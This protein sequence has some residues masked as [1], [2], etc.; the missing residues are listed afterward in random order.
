MGGVGLGLEYR[1]T[2]HLFGVLVSSV[3]WNLQN[4]TAGIDTNA[5]YFSGL[6]YYYAWS[7]F[8]IPNIIPSIGFGSQSSYITDGE[9]TLNTSGFYLLGDIK[10][11]LTKNRPKD[12]FTPILGERN[13]FGMGFQY[14]QSLFLEERDWSQTNVYL[15]LS[16]EWALTPCCIVLLAL[17]GAAS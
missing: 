14:K 9:S 4:E 8:D 15:Y 1:T 13:G 11:G 7:P 12:I 17:L 10:V 6:D 16:G 3:Y 5:I 2:Q